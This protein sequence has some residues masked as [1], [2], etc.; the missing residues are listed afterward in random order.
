MTHAGPSPSGG[1][2]VRATRVEG[3]DRLRRRRFCRNRSRLPDGCAL[4]ATPSL[5]ARLRHAPRWVQTK[6]HAAGGSGPPPPGSR[7]RHRAGH[8]L[9][10]T[11][12]V[13]LPRRQPIPGA[14]RN[15]FDVDSIRFGN[16][17]DEGFQPKRSFSAMRQAAPEINRPCGRCRLQAPM[18]PP[19]CLQAGVSRQDPRQPRRLIAAFRRHRLGWPFQAGIRCLEGSS[20]SPTSW[21]AATDKS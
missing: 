18:Q 16:T 2:G 17:T 11:L 21:N 20:A 8:W 9:P 7:I 12:T 15:P 10:G 14:L 13:A 5:G 4:F 19:C 3:G 6:N 1:L